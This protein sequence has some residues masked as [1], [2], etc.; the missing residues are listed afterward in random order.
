MRKASAIAAVIFLIFPFVHISAQ[1]DFISGLYSVEREND[2]I[3]I[4]VEAEFF[5]PEGY[6][7]S[8]SPDF[9]NIDIVGEHITKNSLRFPSDGKFRGITPVSAEFTLEDYSSYDENIRIDF[10]YQLCEESGT[11][12][13]PKRFSV[14]TLVPDASAERMEKTFSLRYADYIQFSG[15]SGASPQIPEYSA[16]DSS[17]SATSPAPAVGVEAGLLRIL[18]ILFLSF[19][20]GLLLNVMPCVLPVLSLKT[21]HLIQLKNS[22]NKERILHGAAYTA[23]IITSLLLL[24]VIAAVLKI[25]GEVSGWGF[26]FQNPFFTIGLGSVIFVFALAMFDVYVIQIPGLSIRGGSPSSSAPGG[27]FFNGV[28]AVLLATPCTA[29]FMGSALGFAF[30]MG[31]LMIIFSFIS[32]GIGLS[33]PFMLVSIFPGFLSWIPKPGEW[34]NTFKQFLGFLL[35]A[36]FAWLLNS[37]YYQIGWKGLFRFIY[38]LLGLSLLLWYLGHLQ[39]TNGSSV[40]R[41]ITAVTAAAVFI[42]GIILSPGEGESGE[43]TIS[44]NWRQFSPDLL[45]IERSMEHPVFIAFSA[46]WCL[47]CKTNETAVLNTDEV[48]TLFNNNGVTLLYGDYTNGDP[49]LSIWIRAFGKSGVPVYAYFPPGSESPQVLPEILTKSMIR[50]LFN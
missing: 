3:R 20:G 7:Q 18:L 44:G 1:N 48:L 22:G 10:N 34:M 28:L 45:D 35:L 2:D 5:I 32:I 47:T 25:L 46:Q 26:Q 15:G 17:P 49:E 41:K 11:C 19:I 29:P 33:L 6:Y 21:L 4:I 12:Y 30:T 8:Y 36:A 42:L 40:I 9:F 13:F 27:T 50:N 14:Y 43:K 31:P 16:G 23:G 37:A 38:V 39:K 24:G